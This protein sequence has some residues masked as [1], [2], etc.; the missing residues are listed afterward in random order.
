MPIKLNHLITEKTDLTDLAA[1]REAILVAAR[2]AKEADRHDNIVVELDGGY[3]YL[4]EPFVLS[5][6]E[7]PELSYLDITLRAKHPRAAT[8]SSWKRVLG[9]DFTRVE[10]SKTQ[11]VYQFEKDENGEYPLFHELFVNGGLA[12]RTESAR[13]HNPVA[14]TPAERK[15]EEKREG[16]WV[17]YEIAEAVASGEIGATELMMYIEWEFAIFHV[18]SVDLTKTCDFKGKKHALVKLRDNE[19]D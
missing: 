9:K 15:G 8:V 12:K 11:W 1:V 10:G 16:L 2:E 13:W 6:T 4:T 3:Y 5:A 17:P 7:N 14:L 19:I 18:E